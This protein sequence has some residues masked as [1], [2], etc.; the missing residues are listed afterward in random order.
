MVFW[1]RPN[2]NRRQCDLLNTKT[3]SVLFAISH[4]NKTTGQEGKEIDVC[5]GQC[6][7]LTSKDYHVAT[8]ILISKKIFAMLL[9]WSM[10]EQTNAK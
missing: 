3:H 8:M 2:I 4:Y 10:F 9:I 5:M 1:S 7:A 6:I